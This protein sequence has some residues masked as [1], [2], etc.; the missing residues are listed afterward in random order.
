MRRR[1]WARRG[2]IGRRPCRH[3]RGRLRVVRRGT[4][5]RHHLNRRC[6]PFETTRTEPEQEYLSD[7]ISEALIGRLSELPGIKVV[8]NSSSSRYKGQNPDPREVARALDV[9]AILAGKVVERGDSLT[10]SVE[11]I[12]GTDRTHLW[13]DQYVRKRGGPDAGAGRDLARRRRETA[14]AADRAR[15]AANGDV[16]SR[17][18]PGLRITP[19]GHFHRAKGST[20]DRQRAGEYFR[21]AIE[22][23]PK[24][25]LAYADLSDIYRS[26]INS[27]QL[28][29]TEYLPER[30]RR[31]KKRSSWT[32]RWQT[33]IT[34]SPT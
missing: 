29:A 28:S 16:G 32:R 15:S 7:G 8:A 1:P 20:E 23:D 21:Q 18:C 12:D 9:A 6:L 24:Y 5:A 11:L 31:P 19:R 34:R 2:R 4:D 10:I 22:A 13:G 17:Q 30:E 3:G 26:L 27:G 14:G 25:A 33:V